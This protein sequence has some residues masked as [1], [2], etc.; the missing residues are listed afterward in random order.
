MQLSAAVMTRLV[1]CLLP[2]AGGATRLDDRGVLPLTAATLRALVRTLP[3]EEA[4]GHLPLMAA[5]VVRA[6]RRLLQGRAAMV[7]AAERVEQVL[8]EL[9]LLPMTAPS[10]SIPSACRASTSNCR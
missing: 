3:G 9:V 10:C 1:I 6:G 5:V 8:A 4:W 2:A 7:H